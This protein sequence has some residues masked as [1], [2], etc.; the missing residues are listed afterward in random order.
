M[1]KM[2]I[3]NEIHVLPRSLV[4][5]YGGVAMLCAIVYSGLDN[6]FNSTNQDFLPSSNSEIAKSGR[7]WD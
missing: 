3:C 4:N 2:M 7:T 6:H 5:I 1:T